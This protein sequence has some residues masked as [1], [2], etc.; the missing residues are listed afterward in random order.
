[1]G[2]PDEPSY[3]AAEALRKAEE[4]MQ[5]K[6]E[7]GIVRTFTL[8]LRTLPNSLII[9][10]LTETAR[11]NGFRL[12]MGRSVYHFAEDREK[13]SVFQYAIIRFFNEAA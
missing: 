13:D 11:Q 3:A 7:Q 12:E 5:E 8:R 9:G 1:M 10:C 6:L 4:I 2:N